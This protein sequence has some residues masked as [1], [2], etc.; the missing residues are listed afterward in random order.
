M[1]IFFY[2]YFAGVVPN[3]LL[4]HNYSKLMNFEFLMK[5]QFQNVAF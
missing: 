2:I 1:Y 5:L 4:T 3:S